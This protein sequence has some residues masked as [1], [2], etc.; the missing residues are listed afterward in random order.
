MTL[1][2]QISI[3][4]KTYKDSILFKK[5]FRFFVPEI[6]RFIFAILLDT[7]TVV[8]FSFEPR[9][10]GNIVSY[11]SSGQ[12][13]K[14]LLMS[15]I[16]IGCIIIGLIFMYN[17]SIMLQK[18]G[19]NIVYNLRMEIFKHV[20]EFSINQLNSLPVGKLVTRIINDTSKI[21]RMFTDVIPSVIRS[22]TTLITILVQMFVSSWAVGLTLSAFLP[23]IFG[24]IV[25][26]RIF[27]RKVFRESRQSVS[28]INGFIAEN[29]SGM[30]TT[31]IFNQQQR[32]LDEFEEK[33]Q[34]VLK[35][36]LRQVR[37][38]AIFRPL[39]YLIYVLT[40]IAV[41][42]VGTYIV[43]S[44]PMQYSGSEAGGLLFSFYLFA[45]QFSNPVT[46]LAQQFNAFQESLTS[47]ERVCIVMDVEPEVLD[48][49][50]AKS[51]DKLIGKIEFRNV[52]F[53]YKKDEWVLKDVSFTINPGET[54]AF[55]GATGA[56]KSTIISLITRNYEVQKGE[57]LI[58]DVPIKNYTIE[59][60][61]KHIGAML[62][63]VF[64]FAGTIKDNISL[65]DET[66]SKE[67]I[68]DACK[69]V[70]ADTFIEALPNKYE[71]EVRERG[72]NFSMGQRQLL[73]FARVV[74]YNPNIILLDEATANIDTETELII[75][76]SLEKISSI[77][78]MIIVAHRLST[79]KHADK[80]FV[81][82]QGRIIEQGNHQ[83]LLKKRGTYYNL[84]ELQNMEKKV[85]E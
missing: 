12:F 56:G 24:V 33:N 21:M 19:Q 8:I 41:I 37:F 15:L 40:I 18:V 57:I 63:D 76:S 20:D 75:Q 23:L 46:S 42:Y 64:L 65:F 31:Q 38:F 72:N 74:V 14:I 67:E 9:I 80:I 77:G 5:L 69:Y 79:I 1:E 36:H 61:R 16:F 49:K 26:F 47:V 55:V 29:I 59:T 27:S 13:D 25:F 66:V 60:L 82:S 71:E 17:G 7:L 6:W 58:D 11:V 34:R 39:F 3:K 35:A 54:A 48:I 44:N 78:T 28:D 22:F 43:T 10:T 50:E 73:S 84:Y 83:E 81:I 68:V 51:V 70:G 52:W 53:A 4:E 2:E 32:K 30:L 45:G 85:N 62:Q